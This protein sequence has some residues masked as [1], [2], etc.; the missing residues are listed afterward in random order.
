MKLFSFLTVFLFLFSVVNGQNLDT[1]T[2]TKKSHYRTFIIPTVL[3]ATGGILLHSKLNTDLQA[4]SQKLFGND[5][6]TSI[7]NGTALIPILQ[8]YTGKYLGFKPKNTFLHRTI[9][10]AVANTLTLSIVLATKHIVKAERP[11]QSDYLS[12]PSG[13]TAIAFTNAAL[14]YQE[15]KESNFW[16]ASSGFFFATATGVLRVANNKHYTSD[17]LT[18]AGIGIASGLF[19]SYC[20]PLQSIIV[21]REKKI[22]AFIYPQLGGQIGLSAIINPNF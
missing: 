19:V 10:L 18:G 20:N 11:D 5:F 13:H 9:D 7:D 17:V 22:T 4:N 21:G 1:L 16:Y 12:F 6:S 8:L 15:Y 3:I 2:N 14:L